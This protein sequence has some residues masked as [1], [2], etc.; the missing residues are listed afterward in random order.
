MTDVS[1]SE[2]IKRLRS[3]PIFAG[4][5]DPALEHVLEVAGEYEAEAGHVL[6]RPGQPGAGLFVIEEGKVVVE[7]PGRDVELGEGEFLGELALLSADAVHSVRVRAGTWVRFLAIAR[8]DF[9]RLIESEPRLALSMLQV[10]AHRLWQ[11]T[12]T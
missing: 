5:G 11:T 4:L 10:L 3:V 9:A 6:I 1:R 7:R 12:R 8:D 2:R